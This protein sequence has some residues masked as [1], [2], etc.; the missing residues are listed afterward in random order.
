V[1]LPGIQCTAW[2]DFL[3]MLGWGGIPYK[4]PRTTWRLFDERSRQDVDSLENPE[5]AK[6][7]QEFY[8]GHLEIPPVRFTCHMGDV[9]GRSSDAILWMI[10]EHRRRGDD[11]PGNRLPPDSGP[12][13]GVVAKRRNGQALSK[14][15]AARYRKVLGIASKVKRVKGEPGV[16]KKIL[17]VLNE[18]G[19]DVDAAEWSR[20]RVWGLARGLF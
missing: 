6:S 5:F 14:E 10:D 3:L 12:P 19:L 1:L 16:N 13:S 18:K 15:E 7:V 17:A 4:I 9:F 11:D 2:L 8:G 20:I